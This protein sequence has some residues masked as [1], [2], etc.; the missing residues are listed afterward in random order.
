MGTIPESLRT[1]RVLSKPLAPPFQRPHEIGE[2][3]GTGHHSPALLAQPVE[4]HF[5]SLEIGLFFRRWIRSLLKRRLAR[6]VHR[7]IN[8]IVFNQAILHN[9]LCRWLRSSR[10]RRRLCSS[11]LWPSPLRRRLDP[12]PLR[13]F[14][15]W[16]FRLQ[17]FWLQ[18][19]RPRCRC[20]INCNPADQPT[21]QPTRQQRRY[22]IA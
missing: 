12:S 6:S 13:R 4:H 19:L 2:T 14:R 3:P 21:D 8:A 17:C 11:W 18:C 15:L 16:Y 9:R 22:T 10:L 7:D 20:Q 1:Q 5:R